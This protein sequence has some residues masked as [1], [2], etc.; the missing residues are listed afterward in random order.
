M[1]VLTANRIRDLPDL[2]R[3]TVH[4]FDKIADSIG[5]D[6]GFEQS[7]GNLA[8]AY[9]KDKAPGL[10]DYQIGFQLVDKNEDTSKAFGVTGFKVGNQ[11]VYAPVMFIS[12]NLK[13]HEMLYLK[14]Q[15]LFV[16]LKENWLNYILNRKPSVLGKPVNRDMARLGVQPP[17]FYQISRSP[18]KFASADPCPPALATWVRQFLPVFA[19]L[20]TS[21]PFAGDA[22]M[23]LPDFLA[24]SGQDEKLAFIRLMADYPML[25][26]GVKKFHGEE[27]IAAALKVPANIGVLKAAD[28]Y[29]LRRRRRL[30]ASSQGIQ[31]TNILAPNPA[32]GSSEVNTEPGDPMPKMAGVHVIYSHTI[33]MRQQ[34]GSVMPFKLSADEKGKLLRGKHVIRDSRKDEDKTQVFAHKQETKKALQN[35][36]ENGLYD[37]VVRPGVH[38]RCAIFTVPYSAKGRKPSVLVIRIDDGSWL[39]VRPQ[40]VWFVAA[41]P[42]QEFRDWVDSLPDAEDNLGHGKQIII[43]PSGRQAT[44]PF[45][46]G[47]QFNGS[48]NVREAYFSTMMDQERPGSLT[49]KYQN[50]EPLHLARTL[51]HNPDHL[52]FTGHQGKG[53]R[54][55]GDSLFIPAGSKVLKLHD[56]YCGCGVD[57]DPAPMLVLGNMVDI[58]LGIIK[59]ANTSP[60]TIRSAGVSYQIGKQA[61][62]LNLEDAVVDL[63]ARHGLKEATARE[64]LGEAKKN[65]KVEYLFK[66]AVPSYDLQQSAPG[67]PPFP[68][69][70]VG[71]DPMTNGMV[72]TQSASQFNQPVPGLQA[73]LTDREIYRPTD[74]FSPYDRSNANPPARDQ[75]TSDFAMR[76]SQSGQK[77][78]FDTAIIRSVIRS[79][80]MDSIVDDELIG[81]LLKNNDKIARKLLN[82]YWNKSQWEDRFG[83]E[84]TKDLESL[85][86]DTFD[87]EGDL[88]LT[89]REKSIQSNEDEGVLPD[90]K[91][92]SGD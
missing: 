90:L 12:G 11:W 31:R 54:A 34:P 16:P 77:E 68:E 13:G 19:R 43:S 7:F 46:T 57:S 44:L 26:D 88:V 20:V 79:N 87:R 27:K 89:L 56:G 47:K 64:V 86:L 85:L 2:S 32:A 53:F 65:R 28:A 3:Y 73:S 81:S 10:L 37:I 63:V 75:D 69:P 23:S 18:A 84:T 62:E 48:V 78:L 36:T 41:H 58:E 74:V 49:Y 80:D 45:S 29:K 82:L 76:A 30:P 83:K 70:F 61:R 25:L 50:T 38:A 71:S 14:N 21:N 60:V 59:T 35:P 91:H 9:I 55:N 33:H 72:P 42:L 22:D 51:N 24:K 52:V 8:S 15:D 5:Q 66:Y 4:G 92:L 67:S 17:N 39:N 40:D 6:T 1:P